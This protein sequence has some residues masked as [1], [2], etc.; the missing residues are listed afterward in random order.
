M[1]EFSIEWIWLILLGFGTGAYGVLVGAGGGFIIGPV[2]LLFFASTL[3]LDKDTVA[4]TT[5]GLVA[6]NSISGAFTYSRLKTI[7]YRSGLF[8][9]TAAI[10]GSVIAPIV[11][12][13]I[14]A[15]TFKIAFGI[16]LLI[17][18]VQLAVKPG[19]K[20]DEGEGSVSSPKRKGLLGWKDRSREIRSVDGRVFRYS[21]SEPLAT[22][23]N[24][25]LGF[26]SSLFGV[27]GGFLRTPILVSVFSFPVQIAVSTSIFALSIY[28]TLG[29]ATHIYLGNIDWFPTFLFAGFGLVIGGQVG[30][31]LS[32]AAF[33]NSKNDRAADV[34]VGSHYS[35][36]NALR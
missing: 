22:S 8:F 35:T 31:S 2:L 14:D 36:R 27:G 15:S 29:A 32:S 20:D 3:G 10:P 23:F 9:A 1:P 19:V 28:T 7:D 13:K 17:L 12:G 24:V 5:L 33:T 18:S 6:I 26:V 30:A 21:F 4:G 34:V 16:L 11:I 25:I